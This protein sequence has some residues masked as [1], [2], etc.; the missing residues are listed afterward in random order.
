ME[1][2]D[3]KK[4]EDVEA[5][6]PAPRPVSR[7]E[8]MYMPRRGYVLA[9]CFVVGLL[10]ALQHG[11]I[12]GSA[13]MLMKETGIAFFKTDAYKVQ[14]ALFGGHVLS[15]LLAAVLV[16]KSG[17]ARELVALSLLWSGAVC[18]LMPW[19]FG[20]GLAE[21][22]Y[23]AAA[24]GA[25]HAFGG[26][27]LFAL[28]TKWI[29]RHELTRAFAFLLSGSYC[30][31]IMAQSSA[32]TVSVTHGYESVFHLYG[33]L[34]MFFAPFFL[35]F[36]SSHPRD[37]ASLKASELNYLSAAAVA[38]K[39]SE[40]VIGGLFKTRGV[41][42]AILVGAVAYWIHC[43]LFAVLPYLMVECTGVDASFLLWLVI[44]FAGNI[45]A[46]VTDL[47][48][49]KLRLQVAGQRGSEDERVRYVTV[50]GGLAGMS[51]LIMFV[52]RMF[53]GGLRVFA[54]LLVILYDNAVWIGL[55]P[56]MVKLAPPQ[57]PLIYAMFVMISAVPGMVADGLMPALLDLSGSWNAVS[58]LV[59]IPGIIAALAWAYMGDTKTS[60]RLATTSAVV[61]A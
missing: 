7:F 18:A 31:A 29:P 50:L 42:C 45:I 28:V 47:Y 35:Y 55:F 5:G 38:Q 22:V 36:V 1:D 2:G 39:S 21:G 51:I 52:R 3:R 8:E 43:I 6:R 46:M 32:Y 9:H 16:I 19:C 13:M 20:F 25:A 56:V 33:L 37:H 53:P 4:D 10:F 15:P 26:V 44:L 59:C 54:L 48:L 61:S 40:L 12:R 23:S 49:K 57:S 58:L 41:W 24:L 60:L 11:S 17:R 27:S 14:A 30:G 34:A